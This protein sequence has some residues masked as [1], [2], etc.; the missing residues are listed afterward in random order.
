MEKKKKNSSLYFAVILYVLF[1]ALQVFVISQKVNYHIDET[2]SYGLANYTKGYF[3]ALQEGYRYEPASQPFIEYLSV[4]PGNRSNLAMAWSNQANDSHPPFYYALVHIVGALRV[5]TFSKWYG[6]AINIV[7]SLLTLFVIRRIIE[8]LTDNE[9]I[10]NVISAGFVL[11]YGI[12]SDSALFRMYF[13]SMF[14]V[15]LTTYLIML[16]IRKD[17]GLLFYILIIPIV[18]TGA[19]THYYCLLFDIFISIVYCVYLL[20]KKKW[21]DVVIYFICMAIAAAITIFTFPPIVRHLFST[22]HAKDAAAGISAFSDY[23]SRI[24]VCFTAINDMLFG[25]ML[26]LILPGLIILSLIA[27]KK[28]RDERLYLFIL[29]P[30]LLYF[31][32]VAITAT[33]TNERYFTPIFAVMYCG[34]MTLLLSGLDRVIDNRKI[35]NCVGVVLIL[36]SVGMSY[37]GSKWPYL[38]R[39]DLDYLQKAESHGDAECICIHNEYR[40]NWEIQL[41]FN[42]FIKYK[43]FTLLD[44]RDIRPEDLSKFISSDKV[45]INLTCVDNKEEYIAQIIEA[46]PQFSSYEVIG[47]NGYGVSYFLF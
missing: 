23:F 42:E 8:L 45:V 30:S 9:M 32:I 14:L 15:T 27:R 10:K 40:L 12:L 13:M 2:L 19:L 11:N 25:K 7:F 38:Y 31:I 34:L 37:V 1:L 18:A 16:Q 36:A 33:Y 29:L 3:V 43:S 5:G 46:L 35:M 6:G 22:G 24:W 39:S 20:T 17:R 41:N 26:F 21:K 4:Q 28:D 47:G 44:Q